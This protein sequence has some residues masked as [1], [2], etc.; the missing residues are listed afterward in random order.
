[1]G[2]TPNQRRGTGARPLCVVT[3]R[4]RRWSWPIA[5]RVAYRHCGVTAPRARPHY[6]ERVPA[7]GRAQCAARRLRSGK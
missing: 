6:K 4:R 1:P 7:A 5:R 3:R 2:R